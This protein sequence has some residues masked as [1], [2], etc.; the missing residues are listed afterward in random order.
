[1]DIDG[2]V[3]LKSTAPKITQRYTQPKSS[4]PSNFEK[5]VHSYTQHPSHLSPSSHHAVC[6]E[7]DWF[8]LSSVIALLCFAPFIVYFFVMACDQYQC[9]VSQPLLELYSGESTLLSIWARSPSFTWEAAKIYAVW[10]GFQVKRGEEWRVRG[11][12]QGYDILVKSN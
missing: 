6:R 11:F 9:S 7:V 2:D 1:M 8:S 4:L 3:D 5:W 12:T 10:V